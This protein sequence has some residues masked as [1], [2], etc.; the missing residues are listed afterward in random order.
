MPVI[1]STLPSGTLVEA[2]EEAIAADLGLTIAP[3]GDLTVTQ[4][5]MD[6]IFEK[7]VRDISRELTIAIEIEAGDLVPRPSEPILSLIIL[8]GECLLYRRIVEVNKASRGIKRARLAD[9]EIEFSD[10]TEIRSKDLDAKH[11]FCETLER[12]LVQYKTDN[13][14]SDNADI[15]W[16]GTT[17]IYEDVNFDGQGQQTKF[18]P[19]TNLSDNDIDNPR[20]F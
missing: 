15:I 6:I 11:G 9:I 1:L 18:N 7:A 20:I 10:P 2:M 4:E 14:T 17:R 13:V 19:L 3:S 5:V 16:E 12:A 8:Q